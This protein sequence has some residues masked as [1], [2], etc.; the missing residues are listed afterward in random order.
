MYSKQT[1]PFTIL[2]L[3]LLCFPQ[4]RVIAQQGK[5]EA[6]YKRGKLLYKDEFDAGLKNWVVEAPTSPASKV[7]VEDGKL[8]MDVDEGT[9][10]WLDKELS[11]NLLIEFNRKVII[12][13]GK[14]DRLSDLNQF[15]MASDPRSSDLFTRSGVFSQY[16]SLL[17]YYVGMGGN[18]NSTTRFRK[19]TGDGERVLYGEFTDKEHLL[20]PNKEYQIKIV[21]YNGL[22]KFFVDGEEYF[23]YE[24]PDPLTEGYFGFRTV[25]SRQ[26]VD[27][28]K[29]YRL[30]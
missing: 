4:V 3:L 2:F 27:D 11:G 30:K 12:D 10:V 28:F 13:G 15:W 14:N 9:T 1:I 20:E 7:L 29:V 21:M 17:L 18:Y 6:G 26:E 22:T 19:Y 5:E 8:V 24:D 16:D 25:K 23:S